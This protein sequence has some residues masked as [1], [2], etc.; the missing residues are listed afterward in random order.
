MFAAIDELNRKPQ[1][2]KEAEEKEARRKQRGQ[3]LDIRDYDQIDRKLDTAEERRNRLERERQAHEKA[4]N[5]SQAKSGPRFLLCYP[6]LQRVCFCIRK[7]AFSCSS[8]F[9]QSLYQTRCDAINLLVHFATLDSDLQRG[10][11]HF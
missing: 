4:R 9:F 2:R 6:S 11:N 8:N 1:L 7:S 10:V 5:S 3:D